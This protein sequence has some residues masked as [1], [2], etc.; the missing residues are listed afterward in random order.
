[1]RARARAYK[2]HN[3]PSPPPPP[4]P[5]TPFCV[6]IIQQPRIR[7][8]QT[9]HEQL[10]GLYLHS[11]KVPEEIRNS[12]INESSSKQFRYALHSEEQGSVGLLQELCSE[13][14][15]SFSYLPSGTNTI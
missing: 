13:F 10:N 14:Q 9:A 8:Q 3:A 4:T 2:P 1:M 7:L 5:V 12:V 15:S 6:R 11:T